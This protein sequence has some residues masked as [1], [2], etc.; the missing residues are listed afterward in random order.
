MKD[1]QA[2]MTSVM[3]AAV[4]HGLIPIEEMLD[5]LDSA[6]VPTTLYQPGRAVPCS[7]SKE[8]REWARWTV[9]QYLDIS[10]AGETKHADLQS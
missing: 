5:L 1:I 3:A 2:E 8:E 4:H 7:L 9:Q 10:L 6:A